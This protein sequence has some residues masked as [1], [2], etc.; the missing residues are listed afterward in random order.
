MYKS[1]KWKKNLYEFTDLP[2]NYTDSTFLT[3][4]R[5]NVK[6]NHVSRLEAINLGA[7]ISICLS[8]PILFAII[9]IWLYNEWTTPNVIIM[10]EIILTIVGY[11]YYNI[12]IL[13]MSKRLSEDLRTT[14]I[15]LIFGYTLSPVLRTLTETISTDTIYAMT[16]LMFFIHLI[17]NKYGSSQ[18]FF[19]DSLSITSSIFGSLMLASRLATPLHAFS[20]LTVSVQFFVLF[21][22]LL[23]HI[24]NKLIISIIITTGTVYLLLPM[25]KICSYVFIVV[26]IFIHFI[27][28]LWYI[29]CK[30]F[31]NN[32]YGPWDEA[33]IAS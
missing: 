6:S 33:I 15:F 8:I 1:V 2:D 10:S 25:S 18:I 12:K 26:I 14:L 30:Q 21:P 19:S 17:F 9:F 22:I 16:I 28:P 20:L 24:N 31:K 7:S 3:K 27:C 23:S 4:L 11:L 5:R 29:R 13:Y 32:I